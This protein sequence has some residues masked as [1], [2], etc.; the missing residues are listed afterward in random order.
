MLALGGRRLAGADALVC[1]DGLAAAGAEQGVEAV[2]LE[3][4]AA[5]VGVGRRQ[6]VAQDRERAVAVERS[7]TSLSSGVSTGRPRAVAATSSVVTSCVSTC[8]A[9]VPRPLAPQ[10]V[11]EARQL[12]PPVDL[13]PRDRG[14]ET[15]APE[16][17]ALADELLDRPAHRRP[18]EARAG[19]P[20]RPRSRRRRPA[21]AARSRSPRSAARPAGGRAGPASRG[22]CGRQ[23]A[24]A[25]PQ[26]SERP[27]TCTDVFMSAHPRVI[28]SGS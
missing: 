8:G 1:D 23:R 25:W 7:R 10:V 14:A 22:R 20:W 9:R 3:V 15:A 12:G 24:W 19:R 18:R 11:V 16:Q 13:A 17:Q 2:A 28:T 5:D 6:P 26:T 21:G 4:L 27:Q